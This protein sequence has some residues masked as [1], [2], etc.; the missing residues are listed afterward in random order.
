MIWIDHIL[1]RYERTLAICISV[2]LVMLNLSTLYFIIDFLGYDE[3]VGYQTDGG[4]RCSDPH[5]AVFIMLI[6]MLSNLLF[7]FNA[8]LTWLAK[9]K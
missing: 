7:V 5:D 2:L 8:L 9:K 3:I 6:T 4:I 1:I